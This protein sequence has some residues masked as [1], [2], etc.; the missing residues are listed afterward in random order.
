M[1][2]ASDAAT[3]E[4]S[5]ATGRNV[6]MAEAV[7]LFF[8][9]RLLGHILYYYE[10]FKPTQFYFKTTLPRGHNVKFQ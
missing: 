6:G 1:C 2:T 10:A 5:N 7:N 3:A 8:T 9:G 4:I